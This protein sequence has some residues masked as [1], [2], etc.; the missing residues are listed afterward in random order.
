[1]RGHRPRSSGLQ[2]SCRSSS[3][4]WSV[5]GKADVLLVPAAVT[6]RAGEM[7]RG[8]HAGAAVRTVGMI[9]SWGGFLCSE[10]D[11]LAQDCLSQCAG[12]PGTAT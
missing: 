8:G 6:G 12:A 5:S 7:W 9:T 10:S 1:M 2:R 11:Y 4:L 3:C